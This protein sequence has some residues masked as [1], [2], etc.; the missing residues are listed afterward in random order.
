[1]YM[2]AVDRELS[3]GHPYYK[4]VEWAFYVTRGLSAELDGRG[5][6]LEEWRTLVAHDYM[7]VLD[8]VYD[9]FNIDRGVRELWREAGRAGWREGGDHAEYLHYMPG[10]ITNIT[11]H[12]LPNPML[13][14]RFQAAAAALGT[15][16]TLSAWRAYVQ[17]SKV[18]DLMEE[19]TIAGE[20]RQLLGHSWTTARSGGA[21]RYVPASVWV[22]A[23]PD[24]GEVSRWAKCREI[25]RS[26]NARLINGRDFELMES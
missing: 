12:R 25:A 2:S 4:N 23:G 1:M 5:V 6:T 16:P 3:G 26:L 19:Q 22:Y 13:S 10:H 8:E 24:V 18:L 15:T 17:Q 9:Q 21:I 20:R 14:R 11:A 7:L